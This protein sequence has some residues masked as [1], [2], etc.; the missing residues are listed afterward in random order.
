ME[1]S[2]CRKNSLSLY[3]I[4]QNKQKICGIKQKTTKNKFCDFI[5]KNSTQK[6]IS[7]EKSYFLAFA[8][9]F[10][11]WL[12]SQQNQLSLIN[13]VF[14]TFSILHFL[15]ILI[16]VSALWNS[17]GLDVQILNLKHI[18]TIKYKKKKILLNIKKPYHRINTQ[19]I[20]KIC[21]CT[22]W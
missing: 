19:K 20:V 10:C 11:I 14:S 4:C 17:T 2:H 9:N 8:R 6:N 5:F 21:L 22:W 18:E 7:V 3:A 15:W 1:T 13:Y 12:N 16:Y